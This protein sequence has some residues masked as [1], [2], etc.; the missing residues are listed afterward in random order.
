MIPE[1]FLN[2]II[3][4]GFPAI[5]HMENSQENMRFR[6]LPVELIAEVAH[7][8]H[9]SECAELDPVSEKFDSF[10]HARALTWLRKKV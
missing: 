3:N 4:I 1:F 10:T 2:L 7:W 8:L 5:S 6:L 9:D